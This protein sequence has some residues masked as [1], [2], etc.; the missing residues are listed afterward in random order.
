MVPQGGEAFIINNMRNYSIALARCHVLCAISLEVPTPLSQQHKFSFSRSLP[1]PPW[2]Y[3]TSFFFPFFDFSVPFLRKFRPTWHQPPGEARKFKQRSKT[4]RK[5]GPLTR[6]HISHSQANWSVI[7]SRRFDIRPMETRVW[8]N[9]KKV[10][11]LRWHI[12][13]NSTNVRGGENCE[14]M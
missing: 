4:L 9:L 13:L 7:Y 5:H 6:T 10:M 3:A 2:T 11:N 12:N 14:H 1:H 8:G